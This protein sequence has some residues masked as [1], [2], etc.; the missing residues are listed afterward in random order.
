[1][2]RAA[3][4]SAPPGFALLTDTRPPSLARRLVVTVRHVS[5]LLAGAL[6]AWSRAHRGDDSEGALKR[7]IARVGAALVHPF[8]RRDLRDQPFPVQF[9]R[10][11]EMLGPT[12]IKLGQILSLREDILPKPV[13]DELRNLLDR[14]P[15]VPYSAFCELVETSVGRP[16]ASMFAE[17]DEI[18]L[19]S[20]SIA[21]IHRATTVH[22]DDVVIKA[23]KPGIRETL[24]RDAK[25]LRGVGSVLQLFFSRYQPHKIINEFCD[26]TLR[27][28][29]L[30]R[31]ADNCETFQ[32]NFADQPDVV[33]PR[34]YREFSSQGVLVMEYLEGLRPDSKEAQAL[35]LE[36]R[37]RLVDLGTGSII[38]MI[39]R[40]GFFHADLHPG[41]LVVLPGPKVGYIDLGMVGRLDNDLRR[42]L[43]YYYYALVMG[44]PDNA[45]RYLASV[46]EPGRGGDPD[47]FRREVSEISGRWKRAVSFEGFSLAQLT[48]ESVSKGAQ[49]RMYFPVELVLMVKSLITYESVGHM[50]VPGFDVAEQSRAHIRRVFIAQFSPIKLLEEQLRGAPDLV[51]AIAKMPSLVTEGVRV[52]ERSTKRPADNPLAGIRGTMLAGFSLVAG[53]ILLA[54]HGPWPIWAALFLIAFALAARR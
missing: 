3:A 8:L 20:A 53:A 38:R 14:L 27:E 54:Y 25:L 37:E 12:Y 30:R 13:T 29:D 49:Y 19:G 32:A 4:E 36:E 52:L 41:N 42:S 33:F 50:L 2:S 16:I 6:V 23:V 43:L 51:D 26:Y 9:R 31:E 46:A 24:T 22:G 10:R 15:V 28:V 35:P 45:A 40:D 5:G 39:Y 48:L 7:G 11:L 44:D 17:V 1:M 34:V 47:G 21:Q 18:P